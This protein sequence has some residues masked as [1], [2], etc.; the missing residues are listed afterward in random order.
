[1]NALPQTD[2]EGAGDQPDNHSNTDYD[3]HNTRQINNDVQ[4]K[5]VKRHTK[6]NYNQGCPWAGVGLVD[7]G[8]RMTPISMRGGGGDKS[9]LSG[10]NEGSRH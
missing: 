1:M 6:C 5:A 7:G 8:D 2:V 3:A 10:G 9:G 4:G